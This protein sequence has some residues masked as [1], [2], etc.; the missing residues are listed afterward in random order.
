MYVYIYI[1]NGNQ[2][3]SQH[4]KTFSIDYILVVKKLICTKHCVDIFKTFQWKQI[5]YEHFDN[6]LK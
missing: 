3:F 2:M 5:I 6:M 1:P 4:F